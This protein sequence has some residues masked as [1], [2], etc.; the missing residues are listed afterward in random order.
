MIKFTVSLDRNAESVSV[1]TDLGKDAHDAIE[2]FGAQVVHQYFVRGAVIAL[3]T[4]C[5]AL[6][7]TGVTPADLSAELGKHP[8][9]ERMRSG[10][11]SRGAVIAFIKQLSPED[12]QN[13]LK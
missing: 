6:M 12:R 7:A 13:L 9:G 11:P 4:R 5:K 1:T 2:K 10:R 8:L 3:Q